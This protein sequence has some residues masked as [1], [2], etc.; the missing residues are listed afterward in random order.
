MTVDLGC[1][2]ALALWSLVLNHTP[3]IGKMKA[4]GRRMGTEQSRGDPN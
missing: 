3:A 1:L 2:L 4:M